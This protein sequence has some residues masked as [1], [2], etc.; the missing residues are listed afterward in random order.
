MAGVK[1]NKNK[2]SSRGLY[3][4]TGNGANLQPI[5]IGHSDYLGMV[6]A[7]TAFWALVKK[8]KLGE[9][10]TDKSFLKD[11]TK[12]EKAFAREM[13]DLRF[14]LKPSAVYFNPTDRC[15]LNCSYCYIPEKMRKK[16]RH[17]S[18]QKITE[19]LNI[20]KKYFKKIVPKGRLPQIIF[21]GAEPML[22]RDA[23]FPVME[24]FKDSFGFGV[25]TNG[26]LLDKGAIDFLTAR[27]ISI[28]LSLDGHIA[29]VA[30][31]TRKTWAGEGVSEKVMKVIKDLKGYENYSVICTVT[32]KNMPFLTKIVDYMHK[33]HVP[34][35]MLNPVRCTLPGARKVKPS[36]HSMAEYYLKA[37]D[38]TYELYKKTGRKMVV[39]NF[40]NVLISII[41]PTARRLM[42][43]ISP[44]GGGRCFFAVSATGDMFPCSE[45]I[46]LKKFRG[47]NLFKDNI[48]E[49]L[50]TEAFRM[51][52]ERKVEDIQPCDRCAI[53]HFCGS[54]CPAEAFEM[55]GSMKKPG[56]FCELYEEQVRYA[57]RLIADNK[58]DAYLWD[59]WEKGMSSTLEITSF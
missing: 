54:P 10:F 41:A 48:G 12:K 13:N 4:N 58:I 36:D 15:N 43:D 38:R 30:D 32:E 16:G 21:H 26:T 56:A 7:D 57:L 14:N 49:V 11:Y 50:K 33:L 40:A 9:A 2:A 20:L 55:N 46:G 1:M 35:C 42:C 5:D 6:S 23:I 17:M 53:R 3:F 24:K 28:G 25:Q 22:N 52:T 44:C 29:Q 27:N 18:E 34:F 59:G 47:G 45:F 8:E 31:Q 39:A 37:L 19:A 51:V